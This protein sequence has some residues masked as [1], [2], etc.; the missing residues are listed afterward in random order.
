MEKLKNIEL[1]V[2]EFDL[3]NDLFREME[4]TTDPNICDPREARREFMHTLV[5]AVKA[6]ID[7]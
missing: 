2:E 6:L 5:K 4:N 7:A 3:A 1:T